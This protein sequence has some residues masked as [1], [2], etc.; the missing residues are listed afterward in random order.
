MNKHFNKI[1]VN[2]EEQLRILKF[3]FCDKTKFKIY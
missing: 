3:F 1:L 2:N